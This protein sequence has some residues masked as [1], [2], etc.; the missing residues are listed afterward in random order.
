MTKNKLTIVTVWYNEEVNLLKLYA[1]L[2]NLDTYFDVRKIYIDQSSNDES[3]EIAKKYGCET[4]VH[5]NK[6]Y[7]DP[8]KKWAVEE[9]CKDHDW[10]CILD[11]DEEIGKALAKE[12][13]EI[14]DNN[15]CDI[16][17]I[18]IVSIFLW[19]YGWEAYQERVFKKSAMKITD[20]I[21]HYLIPISK[22]IGKAKNKIINDDK[23]YE[24]NEIDILM[25]KLNR[26]A[27]IEIEKMHISYPKAVLR[28]LWMP[29]LRFRGFMIRH[30]QIQRGTRGIIFSA[31]CGF[32]QF[33]IYAKYIEKYFISKNKS[34]G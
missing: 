24:G 33:L 29:H 27:S 7:A 21:H 17:K 23:K 5:S 16:I 14:I 28:L 9:L 13:S 10:I 1:S 31:I 15:T 8:D 18:S 12:F 30:K 19:G 32:Y 34:H 22:N 26:Y 4:Y 11:A 2:K 20:E 25:N 3:V 6:W